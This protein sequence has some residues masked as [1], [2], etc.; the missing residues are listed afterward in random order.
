MR[1]RSGVFGKFRAG[2]VD[3][4]KD[5]V[6][7]TFIHLRLCVPQDNVLKSVSSNKR[8]LHLSTPIQSFQGTL[9]RVIWRFQS[10]GL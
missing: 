2:L 7:L 9:Y 3:F 10:I 1:P 8:G 4:W 5:W 6:N